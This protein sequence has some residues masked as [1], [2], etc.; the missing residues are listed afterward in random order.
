MLEKTKKDILIIV[1][2]L[3]TVFLSGFLYRDSFNAYFFQDDW[4]TLKISDAHNLADFFN[5]FIPRTD[6][7][8]YRP[9]GMQL[10]FFLLRSIFGL[11]PF[12]FHLLTFITHAVNI[13]LVFL[14]LRFLFKEDSLSLIA[15]F[16]YGTSIV[17]YTPF[18][19]SAT[20]AFVLGPTFFFLSF[21][22][23]LRF[24][25]KGSISY[26]L[27]I[28]FYLLGLLTNELVV[29]LPMILFFY[30]FIFQKV[31]YIKTILPYFFLGILYFM[32]RFIAFPPATAT[33]DYQL[34]VGMY[35]ASNLKAYFL[36]SFNW[37]EEIKA[38][39]VNFLTINQKFIGEFLFDFA[40]FVITLGVNL[41]LFFI[42]PIGLII[43]KKNYH[44]LKIVTFGIFWFL[45]GLLPVI[46]FPN[47]SFSYYLPI[48]LVGL[49][50]TSMILFNYLLKLVIKIN[51]KFTYLLVL[52]ISVNWLTIAIVSIEFNSK[53]HWAPRR[54]R[55]S[56]D[57][58]TRAQKFY[59]RD[60][61]DY[62]FIYI[63]PS[64]E[65]KLALND[66]DGLKI[67][68]GEK[69]IITLYKHMIKKQIL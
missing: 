4:F 58:V 1:F 16:L 14:L 57:L 29:V 32:L 31:K 10:P 13:L 18:F 30:L 15:S 61:P 60:N 40:V 53:I 27:S 37:P 64:S 6:V 20:Y 44:L 56:K 24:L 47:H 49:L 67:I 21:I 48:S 39:F 59:P 69:N 5:F 36:W 19:W 23:F 45:V 7:I 65:K 68:Y 46:F 3:L 52:I 12:P 50:F 41:S 62:P 25:R 38:Q 11:N 35:L 66:Q 55:I 9:L 63:Q 34:G 28:A 8:Y 2:L 26:W 42:I 17:H 54:A 33:S 43:R 22:F 51:R